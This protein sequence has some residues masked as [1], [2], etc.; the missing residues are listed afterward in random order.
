MRTWTICLSNAQMT[1]LRRRATLLVDHIKSQSGSMGKNDGLDLHESKYNKCGSLAHDFMKSHERRRETVRQNYVYAL[2]H[3]NC[4]IKAGG[5][6]GCELMF[7]DCLKVLPMGIKETSH[8][9]TEVQRHKRISSTSY[10]LQELDLGFEPT[11]VLWES[12]ALFNPSPWKQCHKH[13]VITN[14][15]VH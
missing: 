12:P 8:Y 1:E 10:M 9:F 14:A 15:I 7:A 2:I 4:N 5:Q 3:C 6:N 13:T 11:A